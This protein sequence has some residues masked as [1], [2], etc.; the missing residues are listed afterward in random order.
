MM[1][2]YHDNIYIYIY[3]YIT[4][5]SHMISIPENHMMS[6][7]DHH[8][9]CHLGSSGIHLGVIWQT[10]GIHLGSICNPFGKHLEH[11]GGWR[12]NRHLEVRSHIMCLTLEQNAKVALTIQTHEGVL[13]VPSIMTSHSQQ[14]LPPGGAPDP[15]D[16]SSPLYQ[17]RENP[18]SWS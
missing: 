2:G 1:I 7:K 11:L 17:D 10:L 4:W 3:I 15:G 13:M 8:H 5:W 6:I 9:V 14:H 12:L 18:I 16:S